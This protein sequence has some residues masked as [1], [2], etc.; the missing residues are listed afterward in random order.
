MQER[1]RLPRRDWVAG[2]LRDI[3]RLFHDSAGA[4]DRDFDRDLV[5]LVEGQQTVRLS[6]GQVF[7]RGCWTAEQVAVLLQQRGWT[8]SPTRCGP[9][10]GLG[11]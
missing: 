8:G 5:S 3:G 4:R 7:D 6:W 10:C 2:V 1:D 11:G 9:S